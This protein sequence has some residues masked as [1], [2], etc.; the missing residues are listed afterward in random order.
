MPDQSQKALLALQAVDWNARITA[1]GAEQVLFERLVNANG[2]LG[3]WVRQLASHD[4]RLAARPFLFE[5]QAAARDA[6]TLA[7]LGLYRAACSSIRVITECALYYVYFRDHPVELMTLL[8]NDKY[9]LSKNDLVEYVKI[10]IPDFIIREQSVG[11]T[12]ELNSWY[13]HISSLVHGQ[14]PGVFPI[15]P[16][17]NHQKVESE[18]LTELVSLFERA[19]RVTDSLFKVCLAPEVWNEF[20]PAGKKTLTKGMTLAQRQTLGL[21]RG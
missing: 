18:P 17:L 21:D 5:L 10:H 20:T 4:H 13:K 19:A 8:Y 12:S 11:L 7:S 3:V 2:L 16:D 15:A 1:T 6:T 14:I 9:Y